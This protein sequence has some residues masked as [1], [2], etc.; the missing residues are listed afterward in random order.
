MGRKVDVRI[1]FP[2]SLVCADEFP[3]SLLILNLI[4][5]SYTKQDGY[6]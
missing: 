1:P 6:R 2:L 3:Q 4:G 5:N